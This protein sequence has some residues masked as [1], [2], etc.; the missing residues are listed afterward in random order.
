MRKMRRLSLLASA[1]APWRRRFS[2]KAPYHVL[3]KIKIG[4]EGGW[5]YVAADPQA[6][7]LYVSHRTQVE[8][9]DLDSSKI[10]GIDSRYTR[11]SRHRRRSVAEPRLSS[12]KAR[13][14]RSRCSIWTTPE[15]NRRSIKTEKN[16]DAIF[17]DPATSRVFANNGRSDSATVIDAQNGNV[18]ATSSPSAAN[19][20]SAWP[21][22]KAM[23]TRTSG[24]QKTAWCKSTRAP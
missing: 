7:R 22:E 6:R 21:T 18:L 17:F 23:R 14:T 16:P 8:V 1:R 24:R 15:E 11:R 20:S 3:T 5:D 4:G 10:V 19:P 2:R 13:P 12:A 9:L